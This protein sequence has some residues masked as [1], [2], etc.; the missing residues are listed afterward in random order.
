MDELVGDV[1][2]DNETAFPSLDH[3]TESLDVE[4]LLLFEAFLDRAGAW[5]IL[6]FDLLVVFMH[7]AF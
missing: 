2:E 4:I 5:H 1:V 6:H 7:N 3:Q